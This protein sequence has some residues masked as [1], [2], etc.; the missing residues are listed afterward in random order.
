MDGENVSAMRD[1]IADTDFRES[2]KGI[3]SAMWCSSF[4]PKVRSRL[5]FRRS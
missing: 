2:E 5:R 1:L 4:P 3:P